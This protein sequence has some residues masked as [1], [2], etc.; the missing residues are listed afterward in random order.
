MSC[1]FN[2]GVL[3]VK[4]VL[5]D[6]VWTEIETICENFS[7][8]ILLSSFKLLKLKS[9][10]PKLWLY[11]LRNKEECVNTCMSQA[12]ESHMIELATGDSINVDGM[13]AKHYYQLFLETNKHEPSFI[14]YWRAYF[15]LPNDF[16]WD[17]VFKY[18]FLNF[19]DNR[20]KQFNFKL[21]HRILPS[22]YNLCK[23]KIRS[24]HGARCTIWTTFFCI[25]VPYGWILPNLAQIWQGF[26]TR[27]DNG[28][29]FMDDDGW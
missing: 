5:K 10:F 18:K 4:Q 20:L 22:K 11:K 19:N 9:A 25:P 14:S 2:N 23:W 7:E 3:R 13:K 27:D 1:W 17:T 15:E 16:V 26:Q 21:L 24:T 8:I 6:G 28:E 12:E 29:N